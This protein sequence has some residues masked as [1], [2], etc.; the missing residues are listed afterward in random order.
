MADNFIALLNTFGR[1]CCFSLGNW[2]V[3]LEYWANTLI[4]YFKILK[5]IIF[6]PL[7]Y[8]TNNFI[9]YLKIQQVALFLFWNIWQIILFLTWKFAGN[10]ITSLEYLANNLISYLKIWQLT[11]FLLWNIWWIIF[12]LS[13]LAGN[14]ISHL[15]YLAFCLLFDLENLADIFNFS[16]ITCIIIRYNYNTLIGM[17]ISQVIL[18]FC[19]ELIKW[20]V[21]S[22]SH[23][24]NIWHVIVFL[25]WNNCQVILFLS[26]NICQLIVFLTWNIW[27][28]ILFLTWNFIS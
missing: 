22:S 15:E 12:L 24:I 3:S 1:Q 16:Y 8:V 20:Q 13:H 18:F 5:L 27:Q 2:Q 17:N 19:L 9:S 4:S 28:I 7:E 6:F 14:F 25:T 26:W 21:M 10:F 11:L 23:L